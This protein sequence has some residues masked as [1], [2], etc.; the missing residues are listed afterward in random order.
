MPMTGVLAI[1]ADCKPG[2]EALFEQWYQHEHLPER[3]AVPGF[4]RG[5]RYEAIDNTPRFMTCYHAD[6]TAVFRSPDY[7]ARLNDPTPLTRKIMSEVVANLSR[8]ICN[9]ES[10]DGFATGAYGLT[11]RLDGDATERGEKARTAKA[12]LDTLLPTHSGLARYEIWLADSASGVDETAPL[13]AEQALRGRDQTIAGCLFIETLREA[14][15][16][17]IRTLLNSALQGSSEGSTLYRLLCDA[18]S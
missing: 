1:W 15:A 4:R 2:H 11:I 8:T 13:S 16:R 3:L 12:C 10:G 9:C 6:D 14:D 7:L 5:Q 17:E 18:Q